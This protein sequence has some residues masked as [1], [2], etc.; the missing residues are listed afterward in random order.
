MTLFKMNPALCRSRTKNERISALNDRRR[1][2]REY[3]EARRQA[4]HATGGKLSAAELEFLEEKDLLA[5]LETREDDDVLVRAAAVA[6]PRTRG[7]PPQ[8]SS[9]RRV[10]TGGAC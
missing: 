1:I 2:S 5:V 8:L 10:P 6:A 3:I 4:L 7:P 9:A